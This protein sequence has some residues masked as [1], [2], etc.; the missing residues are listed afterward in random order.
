V[1]IDK[2]AQFNADMERIVDL[3]DHGC[4]VLSNTRDCAECAHI[5]PVKRLPWFVGQN[6]VRYIEEENTGHGIDAAAKRVLLQANLHKS[7]DGHEWTAIPG[8]SGWG[9]CFFKYTDLLGSIYDNSELAIDKGVAPQLLYACFALTIFYDL[10]N[11]ISDYQNIPIAIKVKGTKTT[12]NHAYVKTIP[13]FERRAT[14]GSKGS[15]GQKRGRT[16]TPEQT[17]PPC[18]VDDDNS[19]D[20]SSFKSTTLVEDNSQGGDNNGSIVN[21]K[22]YPAVNVFRDADGSI[23]SSKKRRSSLDSTVVTVDHVALRQKLLDFPQ[24]L[25]THDEGWEVEL[26]VGC[27]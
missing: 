9:T 14:P 16:E 24:Q 27:M 10:I 13:P 7:F 18:D 3:C 4:C 23:R 20:N 1:Y 11:F 12:L 15:A 21:T 25:T 8:E 17:N 22:L 6:M 2:A 19:F 26:K 5:V